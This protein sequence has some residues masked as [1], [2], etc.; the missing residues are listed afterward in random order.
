M[1]LIGGLLTVTGFYL[2]G[3]ASAKKIRTELRAMEAMLAFL[4][5]LFRSL[6]WSRKPLQALFCAYRDPFLER[7]GF[8]P[9]IR[10][11]DPKR[12]TDAWR[13]ALQT[14]VLSDASR[15]AL[16]TLGQTIGRLS[17]ETQKEQLMQC[18][19]VLEEQY[20][21]QSAKSKDR[22]KSAVS[23]WTLSGLLIALL[24]I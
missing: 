3:A 4:R 15:R 24:L 8:L 2:L 11:A 19:A 22:Q 12:Y 16:E 14:L 21:V 18:I 1:R 7:V 9:A 5:E 13:D 23:L 20:A 10:Q 17:L 6:T